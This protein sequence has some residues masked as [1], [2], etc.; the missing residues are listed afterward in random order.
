MIDITA[1]FSDKDLEDW[2]N[3]DAQEWFN[4]LTET[5]RAVGKKCVDRA[6]AKA[7]P[8]EGAFGNI[9]W[10][11]RSSIGY[12]LVYERKVIEAYFPVLKSGSL[13]SQTGENYAREIALLINE[14]DSIELVIVAGMDYASIVQ[15]AKGFDVI[16]VSTALFEAEV[17]K[18]MAA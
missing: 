6:R 5:M 1:D 2:I 9:T 10:N 14:G 17:T 3:A 8:E 4:E 11:L 18:L 16:A 7:K 12:V 13:G 15:E